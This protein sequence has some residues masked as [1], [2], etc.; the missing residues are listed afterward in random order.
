[1]NRT[2][3]LSAVLF[4]LLAVILGAFGAHGLK[5]MIDATSLESY[6]TGV[7]Y[8]MYHALLLL[9]VGTMS[10]LSAGQKKWIYYC[11]VTGTVLFSFSI[12]FLATNSLT[13]FDFSSI[14]F[15]TP[16]GGSFLII[17][18]GLIGY[19]VFRHLV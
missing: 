4:G 17:G 2:I 15:I 3:V 13:S 8:Q 9:W 5:E 18:W 1:M 14:G 19:R 16:I 10:Q 11:L 6:N 7:R 12:Y